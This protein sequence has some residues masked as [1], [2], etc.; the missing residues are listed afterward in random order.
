[1][2]PGKGDAGRRRSRPAYGATRAR[3]AGWRAPSHPAHLAVFHSG[4]QGRRVSRRA[5]AQGIEVAV[6]TN[7]LASTDADNVYAAYAS[8]RPALLETGVIIYELKPNAVRSAKQTRRGHCDHRA[9][10]ACMRRSSIV[11]RRSRVHR[12]DESRSA[13]ALPQHRRRR[14]RHFAEAG[15][16]TECICFAVA[17]ARQSP[18][19][20]AQDRQRNVYWETNEN[21]KAVLYD[22]APQTTVHGADSRPA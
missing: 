20:S 19:G 21:G 17:A 10:R 4:R 8:Y 11:D 7:S 22:D 13:I 14:H 1:M 15:Q 2:R 6:L 5:R 18:I 3:M 12:L 16:G 9:N